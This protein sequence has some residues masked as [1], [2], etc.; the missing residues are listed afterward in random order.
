[1]KEPGAIGFGIERL[2]LSRNSS[3]RFPQDM[4][5]GPEPWTNLRPFIFIDLA[6]PL[7]MKESK[8]L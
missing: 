7:G 2:S 5:L 4:F 3:C 6:V 8:S 1:M